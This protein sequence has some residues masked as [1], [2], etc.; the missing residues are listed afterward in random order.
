MEHACWML[1]CMSLALYVAVRTDAAVAG[2]AALA[3]ADAN[4]TDVGANTGTQTAAQTATHTALPRSA[5]LDAAPADLLGSL[6]IP[7]LGLRAPLY[8]EAS[9]INMNR[10]AV[11]IP[12]MAAPGEVGNLGIAAHRDGIFRPLEH[13]EVGAAIAVRTAGFQYVYHVTSITIVERT[14][15][16][17]LRRTAEPSI[18]LV[19]CYPFRYVGPAPKR[20]VVRGRLDSARE[21]LAATTLLRRN[22]QLL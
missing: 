18:T 3:D 4:A 15:A 14:D 22:V 1:A 13:I 19:T 7:S 8:S 9:E 21:G 12:R 11:L 2:R 17:L 10:G 16:A 6:E 5:P 20:F